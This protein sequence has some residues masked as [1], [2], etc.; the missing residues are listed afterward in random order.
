MAHKELQYDQDARTSLEAGVNAVAAKSPNAIAPMNGSR[1]GAE[2]IA[3]GPYQ[4]SDGPVGSQKAT[5]NFTIRG[6]GTNSSIPSI[7]P[8]VG[9]FYDGV[10][11]GINSGV[12]PQ[13]CRIVLP[14]VEAP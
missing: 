13:Y 14:L 5:A 7:E 1:A 3:Y 6:L 4:M 11:L 12:I 8:A 10:Y 9:T 2:H